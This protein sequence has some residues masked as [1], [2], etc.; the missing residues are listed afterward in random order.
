MAKKKHHTPQLIQSMFSG[1]IAGQSLTHEPKNMPWEHPPQFVQVD[2]A[3]NFIMKE[4][5]EPRNLKELLQL[6]NAGMS[7]E[8]ITRTFIMSGF[9]NGKWT[10]TLAMLLY[11][12]LMLA[13]ISI[14]KKAGLL[15]V[16]VAHPSMLDKYNMSKFKKHQMLFPDA[17]MEETM[18]TPE[19]PMEEP[20]PEV[21]HGGFMQRGRI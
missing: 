8:A 14:A 16:P 19:M 9:A 20:V 17:G 12:P 2:E 6:M 7:I 15:E 10:P 11:K 1:P 5:L 21:R 4:L 13:L 18:P 3:M